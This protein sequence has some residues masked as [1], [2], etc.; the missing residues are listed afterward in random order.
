MRMV[1]LVALLG[2]CRSGKGLGT[3]DLDSSGL[4]AA[5]ADGDGYDADED[6]DDNNSLI[7]AGAV[8][9]CDGFDNDCD[10]TVDEG[11]TTT[12]YADTDGDG[13]GDPGAPPEACEHPDGY[14]PSAA[15]WRPGRLSWRRQGPGQPVFL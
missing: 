14:G 5:D 15:D 1:M 3:D 9:L 13:F 7:H 4:E 6:C 2:A 8:E 12:F 10:G 11:V